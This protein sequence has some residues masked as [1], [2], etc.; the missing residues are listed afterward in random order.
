LQLWGGRPCQ[1]RSLRQ[2]LTFS[3]RTECLLTVKSERQQQ[4]SLEFRF[5]H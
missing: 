4:L 3:L 2:K 5:A 1:I